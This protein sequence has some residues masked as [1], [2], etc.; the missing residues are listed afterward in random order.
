MD[1]RLFDAAQTGN[2]EVLYELL[3]EDPL[4]LERACLGSCLETPLHIAALAG[5]TNF[6][7]EIIKRRP[8]FAKELNKDGF[9]PIHMASATGHIEIVNELLIQVGSDLCV[10]N[11]MEGRI[12]LHYAVIKGRLNI[13]DELISACSDSVRVLTSRSET[14][15][16]L[17]VK[18]NQFQALKVLLEN[19]IIDEELLNAKDF[20]C[21]TILH[22]AISR[23]QH[24][25]TSSSEIILGHLTT[26]TL[27]VKL[28][29]RNQRVY[30][31]AVNAKNASNFTALDIFDVLIQ[32][33][34]EVGDIEIGEMLLG[35]GAMRS[36]DMT[37]QATSN[38]GRQASSTNTMMIY[39][40][41]RLSSYS[42][43]TTENRNWMEIINEM[44]RELD[45]SAMEIRSALM[46]VAILIATL[47][48][49]AGTNPPGSFWQDNNS[50]NNSTINAGFLMSLIII[51]LLTSRFPL[52]SLLRLAVASILASYGSSVC[53]IT[54]M[55]QCKQMVLLLVILS[56]IAIVAWKLWWVRKWAEVMQTQRSSTD[57]ESSINR[58][59]IQFMLSHPV[60]NRVQL[61]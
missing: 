23:R 11:D 15:L 30:K 56:L 16:H 24:M 45:H 32:S 44:Y 43:S 22:L 39:E 51:T 53:Y 1:Q 4:I 26:C 8:E 27:I 41:A 34:C 3:A 37:N 2:L 5:R 49:Q 59:L 17:A 48:F 57:S 52:K 12:P 36:R 40:P 29:L 25:M 54:P 31:V 46:V 60:T 61:V 47:T 20:Q 10:L 38:A 35:A 55:K 50:N 18:N 42:S 14:V 19:Q 58:H 9:S 33:S 28:L 21:N 13:M 7:K 6:A